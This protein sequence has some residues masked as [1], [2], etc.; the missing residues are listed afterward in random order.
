VDEAALLGAQHVART[1]H[2]E[3]LQ[4]DGV[5]AAELGVVLEDAQPRSASS[6]S[7]SGTTR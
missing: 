1:A 6:F 4:R 2:L 5:A 7:P 3:V